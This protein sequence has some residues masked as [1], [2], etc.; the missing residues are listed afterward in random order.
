[1]ASRSPGYKRLQEI[2]RGHFPSLIA[3]L[4]VKCILAEMF[5]AKLVEMDLKTKLKNECVPEEAAELFLDNL[6]RT[7]DESKFD[8][9]VQ[10]LEDSER[11]RHAEL[12]EMLKS[13]RS[14]VVS[15]K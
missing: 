10:I 5:S 12:A 15:L 4:D 14:K 2:I 6:Y 8:T 9:F 13:A 7:L 1:M 3:D 11:P